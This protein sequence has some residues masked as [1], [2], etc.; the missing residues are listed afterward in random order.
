MTTEKSYV[1]IT[2]QHSMKRQFKIGETT[3]MEQRQNQLWSN[4]RMETSRFISFDGS[5]DERLFVEAYLRSKYAG[6]RNLKHCGLDHF[7]ARTL[8]NAKGA[9]NHFFVYVAEAFALLE[10]IKNKKY[11]YKVYTGRY[12]RWQSYQE[13]L[14]DLI[15]KE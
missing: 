3:N 2:A 8:N 5:K 12:S 7:T 14:E 4:E 15:K 11:S 10:T 13:Q 9:E 6:N 1:Y